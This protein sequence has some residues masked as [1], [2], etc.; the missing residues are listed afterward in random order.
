M[1]SLFLP[2]TLTSQ[3]MPDSSCQNG[4]CLLSGLT[5]HN[6]SLGPCSSWKR[7]HKSHT[8]YC[9]TAEN[10]SLHSWELYWELYLLHMLRWT[11]KGLTG[12]LQLLLHQLLGVR[13]HTLLLWFG[14]L[15]AIYLR[16]QGTSFSTVQD[17]LCSYSW[18][19]GHTLH[20][21]AHL[22]KPVKTCYHILEYV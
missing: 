8:S 9:S 17:S 10:M 7:P 11:N 16:A 21:T 14:Y 15:I 19:N 18:L 12:N 1:L 20:L 3:H 5:A 22:K 2:L 13:F 6:I 4:V